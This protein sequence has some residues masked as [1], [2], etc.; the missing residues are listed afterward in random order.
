MQILNQ[1]TA[2]RSALSF[3][4]SNNNYYMADTFTARFALYGDPNYGPDWW[5]DAK[6]GSQGTPMLLDV[7]ASLDHGQSWKSF[8]L[9]QVD[10]IQIHYDRGLVEVDGRDLTANFIDYKTNETFMNKTSSQ[11]IEELA[12]KH[13][14]QADVTA[15]STLVGRYYELDHERIGAGEFVR[16]TT[17]WN[18]MVSLANHENFDIWVTGTTV[19]FHPQKKLGDGPPYLIVWDHQNNWSNAI[20][21]T[22]QRSLTLAKDI[23]VVVRSWNSATGRSI[24]KW[25]PTSARI[26]AISSG[27]AQQF[28]FVRPNLTDASAQDLA[29]RLRA[30]MTEQERLIEF[31]RPADLTLNAR[32]HLKLQG[33]NSSWDADYFICA[34]TRTMSSDRGFSML[35]KAKNHS[36]ESEVLAT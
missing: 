1:G 8:I 24:T 25:S 10:H 34:V 9:G 22:A 35:V 20:E 17:E 30:E 23:I 19:H 18:L 3:E 27:K 2:I 6:W 7:Q 36:P 14:M 15:T 26:A 28:S 21:L 13:G 4:I 11:V 33:T 31:S 29:N 12:A 16:T 5:G 32:D